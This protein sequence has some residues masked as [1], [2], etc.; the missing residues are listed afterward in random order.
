MSNEVRIDDPKV[1]K[2]YGGN[3]K[4]GKNHVRDV[5]NAIL[6]VIEKHGSAKLR[7][8]GASAVYN[9]SLAFAY[10][11]K[12]AE[13]TGDSLVSK[14]TIELVDFGEIKKKAIIK[15]V[16]YEEDVEEEVEL[17]N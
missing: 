4:K 13:K 15:E 2:V 6:R 16:F 3:E 12:E 8:I 1:L 5:T 17:V 10:A 14:D 7:A 9:A 11:S